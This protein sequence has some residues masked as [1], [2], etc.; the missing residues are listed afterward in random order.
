MMHRTM[1]MG[2]WMV[3][4]THVTLGIV[5]VIRELSRGRSWHRAGSAAVHP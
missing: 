2:W 4:L 5:W 1:G 3:P